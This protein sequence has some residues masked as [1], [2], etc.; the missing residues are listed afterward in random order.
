MNETASYDAKEAEI[1]RLE[2]EIQA[3]KAKMATSL[4]KAEILEAELHS[5]RTH[6]R[7]IGHQLLNLKDDYQQWTS[8][9]R[10]TENTQSEC[11]ATW[12]RLRALFR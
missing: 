2:K 12:E 5:N 9:L 3:R 1:Q 4:D 8:T 7:L 11:V 10:K 6:S